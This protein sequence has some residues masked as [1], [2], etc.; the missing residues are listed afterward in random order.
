[1]ACLFILFY[2]SFVEK[3]ILASSV[4]VCVYVL[5]CTQWLVVDLS[6]KVF[7][8]CLLGCLRV[9]RMHVFNLDVD[10]ATILFLQ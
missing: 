8:T 6:S 9:A 5:Y 1:M 7:L 3:E 4:C 2:D 10:V